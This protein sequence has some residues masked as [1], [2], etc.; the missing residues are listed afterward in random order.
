MTELVLCSVSDLGKKISYS[1]IIGMRSFRGFIVAACF[2]DLFL[3]MY[4]YHRAL[5]SRIYDNYS[6]QSLHPDKQSTTIQ[7]TKSP[8]SGL[9]AWRLDSRRPRRLLYGLLPWQPA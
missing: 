4:F 8:R 1:S 3:G 6:I 7:S 9:V 5:L 2:C